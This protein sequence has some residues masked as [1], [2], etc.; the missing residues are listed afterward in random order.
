MD[1]KLSDAI[2]LLIIIAIVLFA[3]G[4]MFRVAKFGDHHPVPVIEITPGAFH[5][6]ADTFLL[7]AIAVGLWGVVAAKEGANSSGGKQG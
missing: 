7:V 5:R 3:C 6:A 1:G 2:K 4:A